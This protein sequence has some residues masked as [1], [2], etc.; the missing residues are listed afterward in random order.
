MKKIGILLSGCGVYDGA[1]I[2]EA[3]LAM[4]AIQE[5]GCEY[6]CISIDKPQYHVIN[7]LDGSEMNENRNMLI[8]AARIARGSIL[9][10]EDAHPADLDG[11]VI[12]GGFGSAKNFTNWAFEGPAGT[13]LPE[14]KLLIINFLNVGKPIA[15]LCV[16]PVVVAKALENSGIDSELTLGS[17][18]EKSPYSIADFHAG[19]EKTGVKSIEKTVEEIHIDVKNKII[20]A[21]CYMMDASLVEIRK[22]IQAAIHALIALT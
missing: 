5:A 3:V 16:S 22:N 4:L 21:P 11:L 1:E 2:Q 10:I 17:T 8:E 14:V 13:I 9:K 7:H 15:A 18:Q 6:V 12:P 19:I 20:T